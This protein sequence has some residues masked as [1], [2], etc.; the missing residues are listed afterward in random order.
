MKTIYKISSL[1]TTIVLTDKKEFQGVQ[2]TIRLTNKSKL[3]ILDKVDKVHNSM[4]QTAQIER[5]KEKKQNFFNKH[6]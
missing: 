5:K 2:S 6:K 1:D 4:M 3:S